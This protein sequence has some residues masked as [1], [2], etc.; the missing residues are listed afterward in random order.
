MILTLRQQKGKTEK[1]AH[2]L[3]L[4]NRT[5]IPNADIISGRE[6]AQL[7]FYWIFHLWQPH[8]PCSWFLD[9]VCRYV[10]METQHCIS[11]QC[12]FVWHSTQFNAI[13][14]FALHRLLCAKFHF[15]LLSTW[16]FSVLLF[17]FLFFCS[18]KKKRTK[19]DGIKES[20]KERETTDEA[21]YKWKLRME[22]ADKWAQKFF[23][24]KVSHNNFEWQHIF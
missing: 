2:E 9:V 20:A 8:F 1:K 7:L 15:E 19:C 10:S 17:L 14:P 11:R 18:K 3:R 6:I 21:K 5:R 4:L 12:H 16:S 23:R 22:A 13:L 24:R